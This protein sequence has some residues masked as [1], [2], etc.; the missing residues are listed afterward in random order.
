M[1]PAQTC[2]NW[3]M[4]FDDELEEELEESAVIHDI[5]DIRMTDYLSKDRKVWTIRLTGEHEFTA[6]RMYLKMC[7]LKVGMETQLSV[8]PE[9]EEPSKN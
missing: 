1:S 4:D 5:S 8:H 2:H 7:E 9:P 3:P 6:M